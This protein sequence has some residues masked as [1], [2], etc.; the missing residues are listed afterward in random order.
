MAQ[1]ARGPEEEVSELSEESFTVKSFE[2]EILENGTYP[3]TVA[4]MRKR[5]SSFGGDEYV[6]WIF[7]P[8][9]F[10]EDAR[11]A[12]TTSLSAGRNAKGMEWSRRILGKSQATDT[13]W[14]RDLKE[15]RPVVEWG[16]DILVGKP[17][18]IVVE[19][20]WDE[21]EERYRNRVVNVLPPEKTDAEKNLDD[22]EDD[23]SDIPF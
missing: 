1:S 10:S 21:D 23:F 19:K 2:P 13:K 18:R 7:A 11:P 3:A 5:P 14:G 22:T 15:K 6:L 20:G 16:P 4:D 12:G 9:G 8:D 17:C